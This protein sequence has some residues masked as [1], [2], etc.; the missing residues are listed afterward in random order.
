MKQLSKQLKKL[1]CGN[2]LVTFSQIINEAK[3]YDNMHEA[4]LV[5]MSA[6]SELSLDVAAF[7]CLTKLADT[8]DSHFDQ[9]GNYSKSLQNLADFMGNLFKRYPGIDIQPILFYICHM[10]R[11]EN[12]FTLSYVVHNILKTM[13]VWED[14]V[15]DY[16][17][18]DQLD[19][20]A[21]GYMLLC[22][23]R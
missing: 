10:I 15:V 1:S 14:I 8:S 12:Q 7:C 16:L 2:A 3:N 23:G 22:E 6:C 11:D 4:Q 5:A 17:K 19:Q 13:Y 21:A 9:E 18:A 20:L